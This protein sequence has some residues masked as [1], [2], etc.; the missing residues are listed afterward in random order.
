MKIKSLLFSLAFLI[1]ISCDFN[2]EPLV[3]NESTLTKVL[4]DPLSKSFNQALGR[5]HETSS[6]FTG[7]NSDFETIRLK[8][9]ESIDDLKSFIQVNY[10]NPDYVFNSLFE[11]ATIGQEI[12]NKYP[13]VSEFTTEDVQILIKEIAETRRNS[14]RSIFLPS[15]RQMQGQCE[16]QRDA[17]LQTCQEGAL[18]GAAACALLTPTLL[19]ALGC[20]GFVWIAELACIRAAN[21]DYDICFEYERIAL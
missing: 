8:G 16:D 9:F 6:L 17:D 13:E 14:K 20:G 21:R 10:K 12:R 19:G 18:V 4:K 7:N 3:E 2:D 11:M 15:L 1:T 5:T